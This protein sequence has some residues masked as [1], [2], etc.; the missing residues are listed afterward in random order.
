MSSLEAKAFSLFEA[1]QRGILGSSL[2]GRSFS[3]S[4]SDSWDPAG[5]VFA[6]RTILIA[7]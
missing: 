5:E 3:L 1:R 6:Q 4:N 2:E 7:P